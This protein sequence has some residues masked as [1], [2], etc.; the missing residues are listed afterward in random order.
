[1]A[2]R[3]GGEGGLAPALEQFHFETTLLTR[4]RLPQHGVNSAKNNVFWRNANF[5]FTKVTVN[6]LSK[7]R[8]QKRFS[9]CARPAVARAQRRFGNPLESVAPC[10][11]PFPLRRGTALPPENVYTVPCPILRALEMI[12]GKWKLPILWHLFDA[13]AVRYNELKRSVVGITAMMLTQCLRELEADGLVARRDY[14]E[15]PLKVEYSLTEQGKELLPAL[16]ELYAWGERRI[17]EGG[18]KGGPQ[19]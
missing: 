3:V 17:A 4:K 1:M 19:A 6:L 5:D 14:G 12:G 15:W 7:S 13:E 18:R 9:G 16:R 8:P 11:A 10:G 2:E